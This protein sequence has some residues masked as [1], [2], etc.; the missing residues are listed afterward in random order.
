MEVWF[1]AEVTVKV[2]RWFCWSTTADWLIRNPVWSGAESL[3]ICED[4]K[5]NSRIYQV[6]KKKAH[7]CTDTWHTWE[8][9]LSRP[10][11]PVKPR[12]MRSRSREAERLTQNALWGKWAPE[13]ELDVPPCQED[14]K[15]REFIKIFKWH[16]VLNENCG[17]EERVQFPVSTSYC[18]C[19]DSYSSTTY[20][21]LLVLHTV[22]CLFPTTHHPVS[23]DSTWI[24]CSLLTTINTELL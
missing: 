10:K 18:I 24:D 22:S 2:T 15:E 13:T 1:A 21:T 5:H 17:L 8:C 19:Q 14:V 16:L 6:I 11:W 23:C 20:R 12:P 7:G 3:T 4:Y 9:G